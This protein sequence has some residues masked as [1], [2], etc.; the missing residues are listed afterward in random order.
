MKWLR[1]LC[2]VEISD[3]EIARRLTL[4]GLEVEGRQTLAIGPDVVAARVGSKEPV[5]GSDHLNLCQ[6]N[7]G[8]G[9][10]QIVCGASNYQAGDVVPLARV[11]AHLPNGMEIKKAKLRGVESNGMLCSERELGLSEDHAGLMI[12]PRETKPGTRM[13]EVLG[14]PDTVF[15]LNITPNRPDALS[16]LGIARELS[17]ITGTPLRSATLKAAGTGTLPAKVEIRDAQRCPRYVALVIEGVRIGPSPLHVQE[18]LRACG[19]RSISNV[20][21][22]TNLAL[23]ELGQPLH[24]FD[25]DKLDGAQ[26]IVRRAAEGESMTTLDG[27][28]RK[29]TADDLVIADAS[30]PV[31]LAGV[32]GGAT[33]EVSGQTTRILLESAM[34][35]GAGVRRT[36]RRQQLHTE[37]SHR[38]ERGMDEHSADKAALRCAELIVQLAGG[39]LLPGSIDVYPA[40]RELP[41][42][43][44]RPARVSAVLGVEVGEPEVDQRLRSLQLT[45]VGDGRWSVPSWRG[46]L[47]REI[48]CIEEIAR[49]RGFDTIPVQ[50]HMAGVG[51][52][53]FID[54]KRRATQH[55]RAALAAHGLDEVLNY[56]FVPEADL[57][58][59]GAPEP[60]RVANP[61]TAEQGAMRTTLL[62]GLL[63]NLGFNLKRGSHDVQLYELGRVYLRESHPVYAEGHLSWPA[64]EPRKLGIALVGSRRTKSWTGGGEPLDFYDLKGILEDILETLGVAGAR[65]VPAEHPALHPASTAGLTIDG[66]SVGVLGQIHPTVA[67]RFEL[68][69]GVWLAE[70]DFDALLSHAVEVRPLQGV[71]KFPAVTRDLAFVVDA[72]VASE[73]LLGEIRAADDQ[74]LLEHVSLF[75]VYRGAPVPEG[76]KSMAFGLSLRASDRT[77]TD[78]EADAL[79]TRIR[80]R[81]KVKVGAEI[82]A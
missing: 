24:A 1:E 57:K 59:L 31:A 64:H 44:V 38:F 77:L 5:K 16:H 34:F 54:P 73:Q 4:A 52:T 18:R 43:I 40:P 55:G 28:E 47:R 53:A 30:K 80:E 58:V 60:I 62:A 67:A 37:A 48:D 81:L 79:C 65:F 61:L 39:K 12:L 75:D 9:T 63:R 72:G 14:L 22:A 69:A 29:L 70:L 36:A 19:V 13:D 66:V 51:E 41:K 33:S 10:H 45:P 68:P 32:M 56:S 11:G 2:P 21:D 17:A 76:R 71:P 27:K 50:T 23:L 3:D 35:E 7:D 78:P 15:E 49:L 74:K 26:I 8:S 82:R 25:L 42:V 46:D 20:V 6:V